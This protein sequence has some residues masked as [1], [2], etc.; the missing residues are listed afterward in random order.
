MSDYEDKYEAAEAADE[1][2]HASESLLEQASCVEEVISEMRS[3]SMFPGDTEGESSYDWDG[4]ID[5]L[6][7]ALAA[8][9]DG[10]SEY[11]DFECQAWE[12][13]DELEAEEN[14]ENDDY[15]DSLDD[16]CEE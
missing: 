15:D 1:Y 13:Y 3:G 6:E 5:Q 7:E 9:N 16:G 12:A 14:A 8:M 4:V 11:H 10:A 2:S